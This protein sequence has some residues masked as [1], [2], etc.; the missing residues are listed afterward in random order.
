MFFIGLQQR[1]LLPHCQ[2]R[3][4]TCLVMEWEDSREADLVDPWEAGDLWEVDLVDSWEADDLWEADLV[5]SWEA[6]L[7]VLWDPGLVGLDFVMT[8]GSLITVSLTTIGSL[9]TASLTIIGSLTT[10]LL[11]II[12][13][14]TTALLTIIGSLTT[15]LLTTIGSSFII[16]TVS[17][18]VLISFRLAS[19]GGIPGIPLTMGIIL[20][21]IAITLLTIAIT[22]LTMGTPT[23][24]PI[25]AAGR[26][27]ITS[28]GLIWPCQCSRSLPG[29]AITMD[30]LTG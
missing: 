10:A 16:R 14:L 28:I 1:P 17:F 20:L 7:V 19:L 4:E 8:I 24:L 29:A 6:D 27:S 30:R 12:G 9:T 21:T 15:A 2:S 22:P 5:D 18:S 3:L 25:L 23:I 26:L 13:S 11:T